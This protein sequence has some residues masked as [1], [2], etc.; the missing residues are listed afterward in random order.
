MTTKSAPKNCT[1]RSCSVF[2]SCCARASLSGLRNALSGLP[3]RHLVGG[4]MNR[5]AVALRKTREGAHV[6]V[7]G[8][9]IASKRPRIV[10]WKGGVRDD[11]REPGGAQRRA[12]GGAAGV[13]VAAAL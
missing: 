7:D 13:L 1:N 12:E 6:A 11:D 8:C 10:T 5:G 9:P 2:C 4:V 3:H